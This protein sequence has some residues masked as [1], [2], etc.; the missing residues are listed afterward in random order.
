MS[1]RALGQDIDWAAEEGVVLTG[2][3]NTGEGS[4]RL[5]W[6]WYT[7]PGSSATT[8]EERLNE[9]MTYM[10]DFLWFH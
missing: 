2:V 10:C 1:A 5:A 3:I 6:I 9:G 7:D 8:G 4:R